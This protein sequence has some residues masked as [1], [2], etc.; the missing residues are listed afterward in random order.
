MRRGTTYEMRLPLLPA[1]ALLVTCA[2]CATARPRPPGLV[3]DLPLDP[4]LAAASAQADHLERSARIQSFTLGAR[5]IPKA[6]YVAALRRFVALGRESPTREA[7]FAA[8][9]REFTFEELPARPEVLVTAYFEPIVDGAPAATARFTQPL[10]R[11]PAELSADHPFLTRAEID[12]GHALAGRNL[13]LCWVDPLDAFILQTEGSGAVALPDGTT[14]Q[15]EYAGNNGQPHTRLGGFL[16]I[17]K[18]EMTMHTMSAFLR[19]LP[20]PE[21]RKYLEKNPRYVFF[22]PRRG[23]GP[24]TSIGLPATDGRTI[25]TDPTVY[26]KGALAF[27]VTTQPRMEELHAVEWRPLQRFVL[28]QD[29]GS[30]IKGARVDL[31]WGRGPDAGRY[32]GVMK[33]KGHLYYLLPR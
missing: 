33:Q 2:A 19:S 12:S 14:L 9:G 29:T 20:E 11:P 13:E 24:P 30:G 26:P 23:S 17:S 16:P 22:E 21:M 5:T 4:L 3:D 6:T 27:L 8:V 32:A 25:A 15:L 31:F 28:D 1:V 7:F 18:A 10:Y